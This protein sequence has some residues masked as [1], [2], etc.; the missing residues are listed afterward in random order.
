MK[1]F[2]DE[3]VFM[4]WASKFHSFDPENARLDLH[5]SI[6]GSG[7]IS[8]LFLELFLFPLWL[9]KISDK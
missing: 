9:L 3:V 7:R 6:L 1:E 5:R 8:V 2:G 4:F